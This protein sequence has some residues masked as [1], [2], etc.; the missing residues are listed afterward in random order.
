MARNLLGAGYPVTVY[1]RRPEAAAPL[2]A[3]GAA[4]AA[5]PAALAAQSDV[6]VTMVTDTAAVEAVLCGEDGV[7]AGAAP[8]TVVIDHSTID[9][10]GARRLAA[11]AAER[12]VVMLDV[13]VSGG[14]IG[15][16]ART[17]V[18][19]AGGPEDVVRSLEP[20][21]RVN[22]ARVIHMGEA[23]CGQAA[24]ACTQICVVVNQ[25]G[26]AESLTLAGA[27]G[28]DQR[29]L[30]DVLQ[31]GFG[32]SRILEV[33]GP[34]M[35]ARDFTGR[36]ESRLHDKDIHLVLDLARDAGLDLPASAAAASTLRALQQAGGA[37]DDTAA[38]IR[39][40]EGRR[41]PPG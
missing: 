41:T 3:A 10:R 19:M 26:V 6:V 14:V 9:P 25:M 34:K 35:V 40:L 13:P 28:L 39:V 29:R 21:M 24:K 4:T 5:T 30:L 27:L 17:L 20:L 36:I 23:G 1:A 31:G 38:V 7:L 11:Q 18:M 2:A 16:E 12:G 37:T 32:A 15:V 33:Q 22:A 8:G